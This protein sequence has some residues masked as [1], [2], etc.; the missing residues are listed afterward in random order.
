M[1]FVVYCTPSMFALLCSLVVQSPSDVATCAGGTAEFFCAFQFASGTPS[2]AT[3]FRNGNIDVSSASFHVVTDNSSDASS[4]P[5]IVSTR[6]L[7]SNV[8][9]AGIESGANYLCDESG[10]RS[11]P[12]T[13]T[14]ISGIQPCIYVCTY[15]CV[16]A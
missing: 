6:L 3:W 14:I 4:T 1:Y 9:L 13:L 2:G 10:V 5:A 7:I 16:C 8:T 11:N 15:M 12:S